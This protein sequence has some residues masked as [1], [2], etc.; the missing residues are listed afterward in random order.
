MFILPTLKNPTALLFT[1]TVEDQINSCLSQDIYVY[2]YIYVCVCVCAC[3]CD[4][5]VLTACIPLT[6]SCYPSL[7][8][9]MLSLDNI[10]TAP[11][12]GFAGQPILVC[13]CEGV[14]NRTLLYFSSSTQPISHVLLR[15]FVRRGGANGQATTSCRVLLLGFV[16]NS[17]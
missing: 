17:K 13:R 6:L 3:V 9:I 5:G 4:Q 16:E 1:H 7:S 11:I 10:C 15:E 2:I 14:H 8:T 12:K